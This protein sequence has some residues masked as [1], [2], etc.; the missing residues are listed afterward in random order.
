WATVAV[1]ASAAY[2]MVIGLVSVLGRRF[3]SELLVAYYMQ[4][5]EAGLL[6]ALAVFFSCIT[7]P[8]LSSGLTLG[9]Y[10]TG[11]SLRSLMYWVERSQSEATT[12]LFS[13][14]YHL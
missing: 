14:L 5:L 1:A 12:L 11:V 10:L 2:V 7:R 9:L 8:L 13:G 6:V 4:V 3:A